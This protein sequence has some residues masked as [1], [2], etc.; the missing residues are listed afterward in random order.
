MWKSSENRFQSTSQPSSPLWT[1]LK[2][3]R[4]EN[5]HSNAKASPRRRPSRC[6]FLSALAGLSKELKTTLEIV[7]EVSP[8]RFMLIYPRD[9]CEIYNQTWKFHRRIFTTFSASSTVFLFSPSKILFTILIFR[10]TL[11]YF[12]F[13]MDVL[14]I[15]LWGHLQVPFRERFELRA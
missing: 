6:L 10:S 14:R 12:I 4:H 3:W 2:V 13:G 5:S 9:Q 7:F 11:S 1:N 15:F 8:T